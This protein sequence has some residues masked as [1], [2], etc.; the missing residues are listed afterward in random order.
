MTDLENFLPVLRHFRLGY[1]GDNEASTESFLLDWHGLRYL[2]KKWNKAIM[3]IAFYWYPYIDRNASPL[4][5]YTRNAKGWVNYFHPLAGWD[6][7]VEK[8]APVDQPSAMQSYQQGTHAVAWCQDRGW[9]IG[10]RMSR[11]FSR[12]YIALRL[13]YSHDIGHGVLHRIPEDE[14]KYSRYWTTQTIYLLNATDPS[15]ISLKQLPTCSYYYWCHR[16]PFDRHIEVEFPKRSMSC[17]ATF[18]PD[19]LVS[20]VGDDESYFKVEFYVPDTTP[21]PAVAKRISVDGRFHENNDDLSTGSCNNDPSCP[22]GKIV[23]PKTQQSSSILYS[24]IYYPEDHSVRID[25]ITRHEMWFNLKLTESPNRME[26]ITHNAMLSVLERKRQKKMNVGLL[27]KDKKI[28][29]K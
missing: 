27:P 23:N 6:T 5:L 9:F 24:I 18:H 19:G 17:T 25:S 2:G 4:I 1:P 8:Y 22:C 12:D 29:T 20:I 13:D 21:W 16:S 7:Q 14:T 3:L 26:E 15:G 11:F 28:K 10:E